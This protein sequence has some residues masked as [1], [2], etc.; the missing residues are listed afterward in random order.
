MKDKHILKNAV[1]AA[2]MGCTCVQAAEFIV[3]TTGDTGSGMPT[4]ISGDSYSIDTLRSAIEQADS[5][6]FPGPDVII[7]DSSITASSPAIITISTPGDSYAS[8]FGGS[9]D[10]GFGINSDITITGPDQGF[11]LTLGGSG[12]LR[13]FQINAN[14]RLSLN[15][16]TLVGGQAPDNTSGIGGAVLVLTDA[17]L[18]VDHCTFGSNTAR[19]GG[20]IQIG[21]YS[22]PSTIS[23]SVFTSNATIEQADLFTASN[24]GAIDVEVEA[25]LTLTN[26]TLSN[27]SSRVGGAVFASG[28]IRIEN[29]K[30]N[31]NSARLA[32][33]AF[34]GNNLSCRFYTSPR[35]RD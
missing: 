12:A 31:N 11:G 23:N 35:P 9:S 29:S 3:Q 18:N 19:T 14:G 26:S 6:A 16:L 13:H 33:G 10:S 24:G 17:A 21:R 20:A 22:L 32:G 4:L 28:V 30:L 8:G 34:F 25:D 1:A 7:F 5:L 15:H 27:N 2:L